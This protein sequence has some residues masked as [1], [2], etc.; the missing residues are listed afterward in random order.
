MAE[1]TNSGFFLPEFIA[2]LPDNC[3]SSADHFLR[4]SREVAQ[5]G[6]VQLADLNSPRRSGRT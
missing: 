1:A 3:A 2:D 6:I 5:R 4:R